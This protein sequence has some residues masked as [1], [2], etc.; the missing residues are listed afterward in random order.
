VPSGCCFGLCW[1][2]DKMTKTELIDQIREA[3]GV[4]LTKQQ[5]EIVLNAVFEAMRNAI[6]RDK[7][8][9]FPGFGTFTVRTRK[10]RKGRNPKTGAII[11]I[12]A[13]KTVGFKPA[14]KLKSV[15]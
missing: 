13:S 3:K 6:K 14:P 1:K 5:T 9:A 11:T 2:E 12:K 8:F 7:R 10:P 4:E 15:L